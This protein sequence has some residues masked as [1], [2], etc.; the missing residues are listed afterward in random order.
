MCIGWSSSHR[1]YRAISCEM[2][3]ENC[4]LPCSWCTWMHKVWR[5]TQGQSWIHNPSRAASQLILRPWKLKSERLRKAAPSCGRRTK[6][7]LHGSKQQLGQQ[8]PVRGVGR[9]EAGE[10]LSGNHTIQGAQANTRSLKGPYIAHSCRAS[11]QC[12]RLKLNAVSSNRSCWRSCQSWDAPISSFKGNQTENKRISWN[13]NR[14]INGT[15]SRVLFGFVALCGCK[16]IL[17]VTSFKLE[18]AYDII[19]QFL[20]YIIWLQA[21]GISLSERKTTLFQYME[22]YRPCATA[23]SK[24][25]GLRPNAS[26]PK[27]F[28]V[29]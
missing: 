29:L 24:R 6:S 12:C 8:R 7:W 9:I 5:T 4:S 20:P 21:L 16:V 11:S 23:I 3:P 17:G 18:A 22:V 28:A 19:W 13:I 10:N 2:R 14:N 26:F 1:W 15:L 27:A 25:R